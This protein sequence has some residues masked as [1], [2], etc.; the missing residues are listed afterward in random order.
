MTH[1]VLF[2]LDETLYAPTTGVMDCIRDRMLEYV[3]THLGLTPAE[4]D[5]VRRRYLRDYGTTLRG[6]QIDHQVDPEEYLRLV[7]DV[8]LDRLLRENPE[9][10]AVLASIPLTKTVFTNSSREHAERVLSLLGIRRHFSRIVDVRDLHFESKPHPAAYQRVCGLLGVRPQE[11]VMVEDSLR[12]LQP[13]KA[14]GMI[15]ILVS[16]REPAPDGIV[17]VS[18]RRVEEIGQALAELHLDGPQNR[19]R[20]RRR[21]N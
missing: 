5:A 4:A 8:P 1:I 15:T 2:D 3:Q 13:A 9:L 20:Q 18:V 19:N 7:H 21:V 17:D 12:N 14:L 16:E 10:D 6:L 11:C